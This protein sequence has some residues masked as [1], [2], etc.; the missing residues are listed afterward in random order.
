MLKHLHVHVTARELRCL[1]MGSKMDQLH[2]STKVHVLHTTLLRYD[3]TSLI[4]NPSYVEGESGNETSA[5][6]TCST[7]YVHQLIGV[8]S[9]A[10]EVAAGSEVLAGISDHHV[11]SLIVLEGV[12]Q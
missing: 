11:C 3:Y 7:A 10:D 2:Q 4:P 1:Y 6:P 9:G 12:V 5:C 8:D